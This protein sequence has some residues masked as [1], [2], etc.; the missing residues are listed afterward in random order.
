MDRLFARVYAPSA[1]GSF[2]RAVTFGHIRQLDAVAARLLTNLARRTPALTGSAEEMVLVDVDDTIVE[3]TAITSR[4]P[5]SATLG[6][7]G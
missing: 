1:L 2:L 3:A 4:A 7:A 5:V 6:F